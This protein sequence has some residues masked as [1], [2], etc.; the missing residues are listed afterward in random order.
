MSESSSKPG[1]L[2]VDRCAGSFKPDKNCMLLPMHRCFVGHEI[3]RMC[4]QAS[5]SPVVK[6]SQDRCWMTSQISEVQKRLDPLP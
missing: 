2:V 4:F 6:H 5:M 3:N 1:H